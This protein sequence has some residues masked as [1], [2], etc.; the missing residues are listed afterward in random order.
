MKFTLTRPCKDCPFRTDCTKGWLGR[1]RAEEIAVAITDEQKTFTCHK[2]NDTD[3]EGEVIETRESQ[4][5]SGALILLEKLQRPN[6]MMR[7]AE[8]LQMYDYTKLDMAS[9]IFD[10]TEQFISHHSKA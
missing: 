2:T 6:Q 8:R 1:E 5:C 7:I 10:T 4:H 3:D 9:P